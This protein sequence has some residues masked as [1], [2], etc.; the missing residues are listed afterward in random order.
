MLDAV[1]NCV[2]EDA[3]RTFDVGSVHLLFSQAG[4]RCDD[5]GSM[6]QV[7]DGVFGKN[8]PQQGEV[9]HIHTIRNSSLSAGQRLDIQADNALD[10]GL[11]FEV[12]DQRL[13]QVS[14]CARHSNHFSHSVTLYTIK[15][16]AYL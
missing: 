5:E 6:D 12:R 3:L 9:T 2:L 1:A 8:G 4:W 7:S 15:Q 11:L 13:A 16:F 14:G 10:P